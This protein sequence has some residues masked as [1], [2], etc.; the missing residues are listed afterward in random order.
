MASSA[1]IDCS[2]PDPS[3]TSTRG[4]VFSGGWG[5]D[6]EFAGSPLARANQPH[7]L[8]NLGFPAPFDRD[9]EGALRGRGSFTSF[10]YLFKN[11]RSLRLDA[12]TL[13]PDGP[14]AEQA[15]A[16]AWGLPTSWTSFDAVVPGR[17]SKINFCYFIR[18]AEYVRFDWLANSVSAGYPKKL[19][20][21]WHLA[22][23]FDTNPDG[24][25][26]GQGDLSTR[27]FLFKRLPQSVNNDGNLAGP[28]SIVVET[29]GFAR[30]D[31]TTAHS[32]GTVLA[33]IEVSARWGGL[34]ALLDTG[35]AVDLAL[36]WC[37][38]ALTA[39]SASP[40]PPI[41]AAALSHHF[42]TSTP[43]TIQLQAIKDRLAAVRARVDNIPVDFQW[44]RSLS[45]AAQT[46][47]GLLTEIGDNFSNIHG[48]NGRVAVL[49]HEAVHFT[50]T[51]GLAVDVPEWS[52]QTINGQ[53]FPIANA[54]PGVL[55]NIAYDALTTDQAME[56][57]G[58]YASFT[59]E[60]FFGRDNRF[61]IARR[62]E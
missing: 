32:Q 50:F 42:M 43:T 31:F 13:V 19:G 20:T 4:L 33:P 52:G 45:D 15:T 48:P 46:T 24:M 41:L 47:P 35:P 17:G 49:I 53:P 51:G 27:G 40:S 26:A 28:G 10:L 61:G 1:R 44:T 21:E 12:A 55:S 14:N 9:L 58:S 59:Q 29:P 11:G 56:N 22:A 36:Q 16:P 8:S 6:Y 5:V 62:H 25:I 2:L 54:I 34:I 57:P 38:A 7:R 23:P 37:D 39:L 3:D 60:I 18:G 30:Y